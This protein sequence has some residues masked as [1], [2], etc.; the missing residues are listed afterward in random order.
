[1]TGALADFH[2]LR[3]WALLLL[4]PAAALGWLTRGQAETTTRWRAVIAPDL[5]PLLTASGG[6]RSRITPATM[7]AVLWGLGTIAVAGPT[8]AREPAPFAAPPPPVMLVLRVTPS[9]QATDVAPSRAERARQKLSD[10]LAL[11]EGAAAGLVAYSGSAHLVLPP[12][13]DKAVLVSM[14]QAMAPAVMPVEGDRLA[15]AVALAARTLAG[16]GEG[17]SILILADAVEPSQGDLLRAAGGAGG[18]PAM[19]WAMVPAAQASL[20]LGDAAAALEASLVPL[21]ADDADVRR[22]ARRLD[23]A[24]AAARDPA[25]ERWAE[26]GY[27]LTPLLAALVA[28]WFRRGWVLAS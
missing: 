13:P 17:G 11:R 25:S 8:W 20:A 18:P 14:L 10:L 7:L 15:E 26:T 1:M 5:L 2:F 21:S 4:A 19:L 3:P 24:R 16:G 9:M 22:I 6:E 23:T 12:T 28:A 27:W